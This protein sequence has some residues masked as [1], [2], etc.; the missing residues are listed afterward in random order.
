[1]YVVVG[2]LGVACNIS[3]AVGGPRWL[4]LLGS[5]LVFAGL[6]MLSVLIFRHR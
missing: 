4:S 5:V 3:V 2:L 6:V 1:L